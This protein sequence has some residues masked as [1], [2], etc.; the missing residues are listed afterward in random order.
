MNRR[1]FL[2]N[3]SLLTLG[4]GL[5]P[6]VAEAGDVKQ[7]SSLKIA[8]ISDVHIKRLQVAE[9]GMRKALRHVN[10]LKEKPHFII[11]GGDAIMDALAVD[12]AGT[13]DQWGLW[14]TILREENLLPVY[15]V[16]GNHDVWGWQVKDESIK[17]DP[18]YDKAWAVKQH[19]MPGR[20]YSF[21]KNEWK[22][23]VLDST[24]Q[25]GAGYIARFDEEQ[26]AWLEGELKATDAAQHICIVSHIPIVSFCA[27][28]F[29]DE[30]LPNGD[31]KLLRVLLHVDARRVIKLFERF[32]NIRCCLSG[33]IHL[34]DAVEYK[35]I[36]YF[37][38]GAISGNWWKG[39]FKG[40][41]PAY[42]V[43]YFE[44]NGSVKRTMMEY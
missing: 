23:I 14:S 2:R 31:W 44:K 9:E 18:L 29:F 5:V 43:F 12:K 11:N 20:Y 33:H 21:A 35:G 19:K 15:H 24:M 1:N 3:S 22:F 41:A 17:T 32:K 7:A 40:F 38:N 28:M 37:C 16:I 42:A 36:Q 6:A 13:A 34:Q 27:A 26:I 39:D 25:D 8:F 30:H 4:A 10:A